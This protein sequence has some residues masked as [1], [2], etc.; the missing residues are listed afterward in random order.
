MSHSGLL[1]G[2]A[3]SLGSALAD[4]VLLTLTESLPLLCIRVQVVSSAINLVQE[5]RCTTIQAE[6]RSRR[7][8]S[9]R[10]TTGTAVTDGGLANLIIVLETLD[11][12]FYSLC[13]MANL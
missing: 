7:R 5:V 1:G 4:P 3:S 9:R 8:H 6:P 10:P 13:P 12:S 2:E 11:K